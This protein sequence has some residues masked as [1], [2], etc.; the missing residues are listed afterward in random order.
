MY[1]KEVEVMRHLKHPNIIRLLWNKEEDNTI[2]MDHAQDLNF[3][4][5]LEQTK[6]IK[7]ELNT[8]YYYFY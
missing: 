6:E 4:E 3:Y 1:L 8:V 7:L 2:A 5:I